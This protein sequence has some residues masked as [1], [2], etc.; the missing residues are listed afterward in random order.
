[1]RLRGRCATAAVGA[2]FPAEKWT[3]AAA[4][5]AVTASPT[6]TNS[7]RRRR[8]AAA[9]RR[10]AAS[11]PLPPPPL[12]PPPRLPT[13]TAQYRPHPAPALR[14]RHYQRRAK[15]LDT[16]EN[17]WS[18]WSCRTTAAGSQ[19]VLEDTHPRPS[20]SSWC[21][22]HSLDDRPFSITEAFRKD[23][24]VA[25]WLMRI[26]RYRNELKSTEDLPLQQSKNASDGPVEASA[27]PAAGDDR[28]PTARLERTSER[29]RVRRHTWARGDGLRRDGQPAGRARRRAGGRGLLRRRHAHYRTPARFPAAR[30]RYFVGP[31]QNLVGLI[32]FLLWA[33]NAVR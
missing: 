1:M 9:R 29:A 25:W 23:V 15:Q 32:H 18:E 14:P 12:P 11:P 19:D 33:S 7:W 2:Y 24:T 4:S 20:D 3:G 17:E 27:D 22:L 13:S 10:R 28:R 16:T 21:F 30:L 6:W 26:V 31:L 8:V 5:H